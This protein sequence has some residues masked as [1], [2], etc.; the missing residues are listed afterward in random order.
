VNGWPSLS[1]C[2]VAAA[3]RISIWDGRALGRADRLRRALFADAQILFP[4]LAVRNLAWVLWDPARQCLHDRK[5][6][7]IV[8]AGRTRP[9]QKA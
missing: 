2:V 6:A 8:I 9:G 5:A 3:T 4:P 7:S 1:G